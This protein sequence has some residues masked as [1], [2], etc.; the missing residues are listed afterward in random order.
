MGEKAFE[1]IQDWTMEKN[2]GKYVD[3]LKKVLTQDVDTL[4]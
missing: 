2:V 1:T 4:K 3:M